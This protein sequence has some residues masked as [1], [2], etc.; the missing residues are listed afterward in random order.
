MKIY[1]SIKTFF[2]GIKN[3]FIMYIAT[4]L[5]LPLFLAGFMGTITD[6][7]FKSP[8]DIEKF[9]VNIVDKD[10]TTY[11]ENLKNYIKNDLNGLA[12]IV[13]N[14]KELLFLK[15]FQLTR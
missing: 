15:M 1:I 13:K 12:N 9:N 10:N 11:S 2:K 3:N 5:L 8:A 6:S 14:E 7:M 4:L